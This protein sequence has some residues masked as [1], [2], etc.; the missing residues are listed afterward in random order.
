ISHAAI[1]VNFAV[2]CAKRGIVF[3]PRDMEFFARTWLRGVRK[4]DGT[5]AATI[6]GGTYHA[7]KS[8]GSSAGRWMPLVE[9]LEGDLRRR[10]HADLARAVL[11]E[12]IKLPSQLV[13]LA[14]LC[15]LEATVGK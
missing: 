4:P 10:L 8:A 11:A 7:I 12:P 2:R 6:A 15:W 9:M 5:W 1:N 3:T 13:G 14:N